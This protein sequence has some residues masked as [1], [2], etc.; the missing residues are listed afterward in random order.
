MQAGLI[1]NLTTKAS[2]SSEHPAHTHGT[3]NSSSNSSLSSTAHHN[4]DAHHHN[5]Q[6]HSHSSTTHPHRY[7]TAAAATTA[8]AA[9]AAAAAASGVNVHAVN[10]ELHRLHAGYNTPSV[11]RYEPAPGSQLLLLKGQVR[12]LNLYIKNTLLKVLRPHLESC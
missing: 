9:A 7:S 4:A 11:M 6:R 5:Q 3:N 8:A 12:M 10:D 1:R 2:S